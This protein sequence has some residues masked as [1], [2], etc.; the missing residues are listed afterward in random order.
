MSAPKTRT[1]SVWK[2]FLTP[3]WVI[4][5]ILALAFSWFAITWLS[6]WQLNKDHDIVERNERIETAFE[7][8]P[9]PAATLLDGGYDPAD[10]WTRISLTG[11][12]VP[13]DEV[14]IR[15]R[16]VDG[17][18]AFQSLVPFQLDDDSSTV[19]LINR[20]WVPA[21]DGGTT[22]PELP[23]PPATET[24]TLNAM[25]RTPEDPH[26]EGATQDQGYT[27]V[28][29]I[30]PAQ[31]AELTE[32]GSDFAE[33]YAQLL[34]DQPGVLNPIPLPQLDRG[35]HL[36]YGLQWIAFGIMAPAGLI[37]FLYSEVRERRR[38][39]QEQEELAELVNPIADDSPAPA[40][41]SSSASGT[42][43]TEPKGPVAT[44]APARARYGSSRT[45]P[46]AQKETEER[47]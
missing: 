23:A 12:Y 27:M 41:V 6:P 28:Q 32:S 25:I 8:D 47:F 3:G 20:G 19:I 39:R 26:P 29:S 46:W 30:S 5:F 44:A 34:S 18:P 13:D 14:L 4:A 38:Y 15:L 11:R 40:P 21:E 36:S 2:S 37:Y 35:N 22:V 7:A 10:E 17:A 31:I 9:V 1:G 16:P 43:E 42:T 24:V 45:N 33:P